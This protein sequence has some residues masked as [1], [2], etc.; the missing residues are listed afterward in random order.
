MHMK[1]N[2]LHKTHT[3]EQVLR[4][5]SKT[6]HDA[7]VYTIFLLILI[8]VSWSLDVL[9]GKFRETQMLLWWGMPAR[10][11]TSEGGCR[12]QKENSHN[13][14]RIKNINF[15]GLYYEY[16]ILLPSWLSAMMIM[17]LSWGGSNHPNSPSFLSI[18]YLS[19]AFKIF[20][21]SWL[22]MFYQFLLYNKVTHIYIFIHSFSHIIL[23]HVPSQVIA[24]SSLYHTAESHC[25]STPNA[26]ICIY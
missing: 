17:L 3:L 1:S 26:I 2:K 19:L 4:N 21:Y 23:H 8:I 22:M 13:P 24:H 6:V 15:I 16:C 10:G 14:I 9:R 11:T 18:F 25:L 12:T 7:I 5:H 20:H